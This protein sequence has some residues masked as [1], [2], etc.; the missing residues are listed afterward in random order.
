MSPVTNYR[1]DVPTQSQYT[2]SII[3]FAIMMMITSCKKCDDKEALRC[4]VI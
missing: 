3:L 1:F 2:Y 4:P